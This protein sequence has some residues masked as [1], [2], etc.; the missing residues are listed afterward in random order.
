MLGALCAYIVLDNQTAIDGW[1]INMSVAGPLGIV[2]GFACCLFAFK[3]FYK[4]MKN[5]GWKIG[6]ALG[7]LYSGLA[8]VATGAITGIGI[9]I[10]EYQEGFGEVAIV[11]IYGVMFGIIQGI[12]VGAIAGL[13]FGPIIT[14]WLLQADQS[15]S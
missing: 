15:S 12:V 4:D 3:R 8:G 7:A 5:K 13:I 11:A 6:I 1:Q 9:G 2:S 14:K 10:S